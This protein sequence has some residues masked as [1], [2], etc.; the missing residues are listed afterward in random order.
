MSNK[1]TP[2]GLPVLTEDTLDMHFI[3]EEKL[4]RETDEGL[5][6]VMERRGEIFGENSVL[7]EALDRFCREYG[8]ETVITS[9]LAKIELFETSGHAKKFPEELFHV[10][11]EQ[12]SEFILKPVQ[13]P[14]QTQIYASRQRSYKDLPI[15]YMESEKQYRAEKTGEVCGLNRVYAITVEDGHSFCTV[16]QVKDEVIGMINIIK[17]FYSAIGLW[18]NHW[19]SLSVRDYKHPE[20]YI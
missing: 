19:V 8:F 9:H 12:S 13:C 18:E 10:T 6:K 20:K 7:E 3:E 4:D 15:R 17:D 1:Y 16:D 5:L 2:E 14:H 11:S